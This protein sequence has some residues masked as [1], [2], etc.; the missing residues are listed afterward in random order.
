MEWMELTCIY[1]FSEKCE[2]YACQ[3]GV[4]K[5]ENHKEVCI[6]PSGFDLINNKCEDINEC[7]NNPCPLNAQCDNTMGSFKCN[8]VN[9]TIRDANSGTCKMPGECVIDK[10][11][12]EQTKCSKNRC[13]N[14]CDELNCGFNA[15][16]AVIKHKPICECEPD[17]QGDPYKKCTKLQCVK[18][19][20]CSPEEACSNNLCINSCSLPRACG[21]NTNCLSKAHVGYCFCMPGYTGDPVLGCVPIQYCNDDS[22]CSSGTK[23]VE[24]LCLGKY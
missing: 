23:C 20:D 1:V 11:C 7:I 22:R 2:D 18:D 14:P 16:C 12:S 21:K 8:C 9:G 4:C 15:V 6:C 24:N 3:G 10:D 17:S 5:I 19:S 13:I